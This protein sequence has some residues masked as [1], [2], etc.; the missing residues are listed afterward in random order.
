MK[1]VKSARLDTQ[2]ESWTMF[3]AFGADIDDDEPDIPDGVTVRAPVE[4]GRLISQRMAAWKGFL[5]S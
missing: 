3:P 5:Q 1:R 4:L 2:E